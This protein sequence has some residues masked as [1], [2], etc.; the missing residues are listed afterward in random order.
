M[1]TYLMRYLFPR[2]S[3]I[4]IGSKWV[5]EDQLSDF[6]N[7][8]SLPILYEVLDVKNDFVK[9]LAKS[10]KPGV[11]ELREDS[12]SIKAFYGCYR[13]IENE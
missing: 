2:K 1:I 4:T 12:C 9:Y 5:H 7:P 13:R 6:K 11:G 8:F 3:Q 10:Q